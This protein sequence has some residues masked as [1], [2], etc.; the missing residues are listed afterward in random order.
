[1]GKLDQKIAVIT[2]GNS[3]IGLA[4]ARR[5]K[6]EGATVIINA[7]NQKRLAETRAEL[8]DQFDI[9]QAD[10][11]NLADLDRFYATIK[12]KYGRIDVLFLNAGIAPTA[13]VTMATE[14]H[15]D[16]LFNVNVKGVY[17]GVQK[18]LDLLA[19]GASVIITTSVVNQKGM[20]GMSVY[21]A[22]KAAVRSF[23]RTLSAELAPRGI[24]VNALSPGPIET[25]LLG[26]MG[27][28]EETAKGFAQVITQKVPL[29]RFGSAEEIAKP[30]LFL[31]SDD[32]SYVAGEELVVDGGMA[33]A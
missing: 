28:D 13:P 1:M 7:R 5:F 4:S 14:A 32:S 20:A 18:A 6:E 10:V 19:D 3:G 21:S 29:A 25:P 27:L 16:Q 26:K 17:F 24:R 23:A 8:G 33:F 15:F 30:A 12:E 11:T 22:T 9:L 31:A 2:G